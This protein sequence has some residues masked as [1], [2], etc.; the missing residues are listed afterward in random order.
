MS[1]GISHAVLVLLCVVPLGLTARTPKMTVVFVIDQLSA[2]Y[3]E[4][5]KPFLTGG[6]PFLLKDGV[7]YANAFYDASPPSTGHDHALLTSGTYGA[8]HGIINN[9]WYSNN[10]KVKCDEDA[11]RSARVF[12]PDGT[13]YPYGRSAKNMLV[14][15]L[16]DQ[17]ILH[18]YPHAHNTV[19]SLSM[20][21]RASILMA[22][23]LGKAAWFDDTTGNYTS[24]RAYFEQLPQWIKN[25]NKERALS[26]KKSITWKPFYP[27]CSPAYN[28]KDATNYTF[29]SSEEPLINKTHSLKGVKGYK[30]I[31]ARMPK[32]HNH[33][34]KLAKACI[35]ANFSGKKSDRF[36][37]WLN[38][39]LL[40][41]VGHVY[42]PYSR[43]ALDA[44]YHL[45]HQLLNFIQ[46][47]YKKVKQEDALFILTADHGVQP[48]PE[49]MRER[50]Y[51]TARRYD[52][53]TLIKQIN[54]MIEKKFGIKGLIHSFAVPQFYFDQNRLSALDRSTKQKVMDTVKEYLMSLPG[55]RK[56][57][58]FEELEK[59]IFEKYDLD[60]FIKKLLCR[61]R[62]GSLLYSTD[63]YT[64]LYS[65]KKGAKHS[66][67]Y[68]YDTKVPLIFYQAGRFTKKKIET[69]RYMTQV[70]VTLAALLKVPRPSAARANVLPEILP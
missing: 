59:T 23:K 22:G 17:L 27:L 8:V 57:W 16:S 42:G 2:H 26:T 29:A 34:F 67:P 10:S 51:M 65:K 53:P 4:K 52:A 5:L 43:E 9:K 14:D 56:A 38:I 66:S 33:F 46:S 6:I 63:P 35:N 62:S 15:N 32:A 55:I 25:F 60:S 12:A 13:V 70:S 21:S 61:N 30:K 41:K 44:I 45:D 49:I 1:H 64:S 40:D 39:S 3:L 7:E 54:E 68:A 24:S 58:T 31:Y 36:I 19:W 48:I 20:K 28:F 11:S 37:L 50:G 69:N 18:S 47:V